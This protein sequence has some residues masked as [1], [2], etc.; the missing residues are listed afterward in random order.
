[1]SHPSL[2]QDL[3]AK[4]F[5]ERLKPI[6]DEYIVA[7]PIRLLNAITS[8]LTLDYAPFNLYNSENEMLEGYGPKDL[9]YEVLFNTFDMHIAVGPITLK[10]KAAYPYMLEA[11]CKLHDYIELLPKKKTELT[12]VLAAALVLK[13]KLPHE[14][15]D[16]VIVP[17]M[18]PP[19]FLILGVFRECEFWMGSTG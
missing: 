8:L 2:R 1:M 7:P 6:L 16:Q 10:D 5:V 13:Q 3:S 18:I 12:Q 11:I 4:L 9:F 19:E 17:M 14:L 15:V